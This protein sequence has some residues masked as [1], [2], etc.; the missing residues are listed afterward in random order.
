MKRKDDK[1]KTNRVIKSWKAMD[2]NMRGYNGFQYEQGGEYEQPGKILACENGFHASGIPITL[3][4]IYPPNTGRYFEVEQSGTIDRDGSITASS[5]I[6]IGAEIGFEEIAQAQIKWAKKN[7]RFKKIGFGEKEIDS[8][9]NYEV[10]ITGED[11]LS[12]SNNCGMSIAKGHGIAKAGFGGVAQ[13]TNWGTSI[14]EESGVSISKYSG[15]SVAGDSG[16]AKSDG[17]GLSVVYQGGVASAGNSGTSISSDMGMS[18]TGNCGVSVARNGVSISGHCGIS[19]SKSIAST[20][21]NGIA[22]A[23]GYDCMV[24]GGKGAFLIVGEQEEYGRETASWK[25]V[26]VDGEVIKEDTWY[27]LIGGE[28]VEVEAEETPKFKI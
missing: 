25:A 2:E 1:N 27:R 26:V 12:V 9:G 13:T 16:I 21:K 10:A 20:K 5:K 6:K 23:L 28:F 7:A 11:G 24:K 18:I 15:V 4:D 19:V 8:A 22:C 17:C 14:S 3:L